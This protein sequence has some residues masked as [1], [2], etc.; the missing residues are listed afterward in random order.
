MEPMRLARLVALA[1]R[2]AADIVVD[3]LLEVDAAG[4][5]LGPGPF[6][7]IDA[8]LRQRDITLLDWAQ[9]NRTMTEGVCIGYLKPLFRRE[10]LD[11]LRL[12]YDPTLRNS[13]DYYIVAHLLARGASMIYT[14]EALYRYTRSSSSTSSRLLPRDTAAWIDAEARFMAEHGAGLNPAESEEFRRRAT[15]LRNVHTW[16]RAHDA[17]KSRRFASFALTLA[18]HP[19][20]S[21]FVLSQY[22][23]AGLGKLS[24]AVGMGR[25]GGRIRSEAQR[26]T[27]GQA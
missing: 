8:F 7:R 21:A 13:E 15:I 10:T 23:R 9:N 26:Q 22:A 12:R 11:R 24:N 14:P 1:D 25:G 3:N 18:E 19:V 4:A 16:A 6:L 20:S 17:L 27:T 2:G 5:P